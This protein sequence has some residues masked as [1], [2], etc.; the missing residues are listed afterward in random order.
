MSRLMTVHSPNEPGDGAAVITLKPAEPIAGAD[1]AIAA[2]TA[3]LMRIKTARDEAA[4]RSLFGAFASPVNGYLIRSGLSGA[5]SENVLQDIMLAV[6]QK[7]NLFDPEIASARTWI[8]SLARNRLIDLKRA[9]KRESSA[10][11]LYF[12]E[13]GDDLLQEED[14]LARAFGT[15]LAKRLRELPPEQAQV[16]VMTYVEGK[17]HREI[18]DE[19]KL[20]IGTVKSRV[21]LGY[22]RLQL[23]TGE[24]KT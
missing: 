19:L 11:E 3:L 14:H 9:E 10:F 24:A 13:R 20:P 5:D 7:A 6:W 17:S 12:F 23:L 18:A 16:L 21:R 2:E 15:R 8:Y 22:Q 1:P 4:F